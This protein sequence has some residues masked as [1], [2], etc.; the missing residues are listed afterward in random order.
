LY[1]NHSG[2]IKERENMAKQLITQQEWNNT[3][4]Q[5][6][7]GSTAEER[8]NMP[9]REQAGKIVRQMIKERKAI[10]T[11]TLEE[12]D[13]DQPTHLCE[14]NGARPSWFSRNQIKRWLNKAK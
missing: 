13:R 2:G 6:Y 12:I 11:T 5:I 9:S 8:N 1:H 10:G 4:K 14:L 7:A 3:H